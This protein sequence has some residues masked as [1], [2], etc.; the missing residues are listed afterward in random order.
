MDSELDWGRWRCLEELGCWDVV[1]SH[2]CCSVR[3]VMGWLAGSL[4]RWLVGRGC[5]SSCTNDPE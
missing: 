5:L 2:G 3:L 4:A 1:L